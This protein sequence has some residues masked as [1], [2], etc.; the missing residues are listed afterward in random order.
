MTTPNAID[1]TKVELLRKRLGLSTTDMAAAFL[2]SRMS[3][4][5]WVRGGKMRAA[6]SYRARKVIRVLLD[7]MKDKQWDEEV[8]PLPPAER[9]ERLLALVG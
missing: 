7:L 9:R 8:K 4:Y 5:L 1:F 3:Y 6:Q 2:V